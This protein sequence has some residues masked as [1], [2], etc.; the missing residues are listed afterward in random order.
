MIKIQS[1]YNLKLTSIGSSSWQLFISKLDDSSD[2]VRIVYGI[3]EQVGG[4]NRTFEILRKVVI[5]PPNNDSDPVFMGNFHEYIMKNCRV[6]AAYQT[7]KRHKG[8]K[9]EGVATY[10]ALS[11]AQSKWRSSIGSTTNLDIKELDIK[12]F[13]QLYSKDYK[14]TSSV[15]ALLDS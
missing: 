2:Y 11:P 12:Y 10:I 3:T 6:W 4:K 7:V 8:K 13:E 9:G 14:L 1:G 5:S 15:A